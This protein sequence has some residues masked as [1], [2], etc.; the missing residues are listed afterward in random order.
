MTP[1][2][3]KPARIKADP[4]SEGGPG[5]R[6]SVRH[7]LWVIAGLVAVALL[8][9]WLGPIL[10][11]FLI[12]AMFAYLGNPAVN[13]ASTHGIP[14]TLGTVLVLIVMILIV[15]ALVLVVFGGRITGWLVARGHGA[16]EHVGPAL[17]AVVLGAGVYGG[18]FGAAQGVLLMGFLGLFLAESLQRQNALKN[19]LAG[20]VNFVAAVVFIATTHVDWAAAA[21]IAVGSVLGGLLG[22]RIGR[23]LPPAVLR[24]TIVV[25]GLAA[26]VKLL[27]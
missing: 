9:H 1:T 16:T 22:A 8:L 15:L 2:N 10:T 23:R 3:P 14:R 6:L 21:L 26:I 25:V 27:V 5:R 7:Y 24:A 12:G 19:V 4:P 18:Y 20:V 11:P 13:W 17:W